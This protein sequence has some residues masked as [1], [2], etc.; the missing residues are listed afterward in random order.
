MFGNCASVPDMEVPKVDP[1]RV[2]PLTG[3]GELGGVVGVAED[4]GDGVLVGD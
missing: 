3:G 2:L 4:V 1:I